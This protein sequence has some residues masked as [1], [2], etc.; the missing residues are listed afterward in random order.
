TGRGV[1]DLVLAGR[2][3][4]S[5]PGAAELVADLEALGARVRVVACDVADRDAVAALVAEAGRER[6]LRGVVHTA[7]VLDDGVLGSLDAARL[8]TV[9]RPKADAAWHLHEA[10]RDLDLDAFV[11]FSSVAGVLGGAGQA[12]YA[13]GNAYLDA[14]A[15]SRRADGLAGLSMAWGPWEQGSGMT[16]T[17]GEAE[18]QRLARSGMP[19]LPAEQG[20]ELFDTLLA[21]G[22][23]GRAL[24][25]PVR[26][27]LAA[28]RALDEVPALLRGLVRT[29]PRRT[30]AAG[31][32][33]DADALVRRLAGLGAPEQDEILLA[34]VRGGAADVLGHT[35]ATAVGV[36]QQFQELGFDS[37]TAVEYRNRLNAAT[38]LRLPATL[39]FDFPTPAEVV[40]HLRS[41]LVV[42]EPAGA[43]AVLAAL[44]GLERAIAGLH[45]DD[46]GEHRRVAGR[47]E[48]LRTK[49]AGLHAEDRPSDPDG[50]G[51]GDDT[52]DDASDDDMF[53]LLN[54]ELGLG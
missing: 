29:T 42:A 41:R 46:E 32:A 27:D 12:N 14:L 11:L 22:S 40:R 31:T 6:P 52:L 23:T 13:A 28:L 53:A 33:P 10:T 9:L 34:L 3:G 54:D 20:L 50:D 47:I 45:V 24:V 8:D 43:D 16:G 36:R 30:A 15:A 49:W 51:A 44:D 2:R 18:A 39:L 1:R 48:V 19:P 26:L 17:L 38:G 21:A 25:L 5:A 35:D 7:G 4:P 37:L